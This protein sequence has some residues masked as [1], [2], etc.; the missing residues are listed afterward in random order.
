MFPQLPQQ[1][2]MPQPQDQAAPSPDVEIEDP[3]GMESGPLPPSPEFLDIGVKAAELAREF[4]GTN[5]YKDPTKLKPHL[6]YL[7]NAMASKATAAQDVDEFFSKEN[8]GKSV[9]EI[10][11]AGKALTTQAITD[12]IGQMTAGL[13]D[14]E[15]AAVAE[16]VKEQYDQAPTQVPPGGQAPPDRL[17]EL[18]ALMAPGRDVLDFFP[19]KFYK[20]DIPAP[21]DAGQD[22]FDK[23]FGSIGKGLT[24]MP[25]AGKVE[26]AL[27]GKWDHLLKSLPAEAQGPAKEIATGRG[28]P[29]TLQDYLSK[30]SDKDYKEQLAAVQSLM[31]NRPRPERK[32]KLEKP[33][34]WHMI[35]AGMLA[36]MNPQKAF[37]YLQ[38]P[39]AYQYF[40]QAQRQAK[41]DD[42]FELLTQEWEDSIAVAKLGFE[43]ARED[44][45]NDREAAV[46]DFEANQSA[47]LKADLQADKFNRT[48]ANSL[49]SKLSDPKV[50]LV[51]RQRIWDDIN[52]R[53]P[54]FI[55]TTRPTEKFD[56]ELLS[57]AKEA[58]TRVDT[59]LAQAKTDAIPFDNALKEVKA[60]LG[61]AQ[62]EGE[63]QDTAKAKAQT[64]T[65]LK[66]YE[67]LE[68]DQR[69]QVALA[70][71]L[72]GDRNKRREFQE[73]KF[74]A[75]QEQFLFEV[76]DKGRTAALRQITESNKAAAAIQKEVGVLDKEIAAQDRL[77]KVGTPA[78][79]KA[80]STKKAELV[81]ARKAKTDQIATIKS[82]Q[83]SAQSIID[84][85]N[86]WLP[87]GGEPEGA[88]PLAP[89]PTSA[90]AVVNLPR[91]TRVTSAALG[92]NKLPAQTS[93]LSDYSY[94]NQLLAWGGYQ[95]GKV[96]HSA[97]KPVP[98]FPGH[99]MMPEAADKFGE[100]VA[101]AK[102]DGVAIRITDSY[103]DYEGQVDVKARNGK[104][105]AEPGSSNHG[106][107]RALDLNT[108]GLKVYDWLKANAHKYGFQNPY[109]LHDKK[110]VDENWHWEY[111]G[112]LHALA[113][114]S[115]QAGAA[116]DRVKGVT[117]KLKAE[118]PSY[119]MTPGRTPGEKDR[120]EFAEWAAG[121]AEER[122][123]PPILALIGA[124]VETGMRNL[125]GGDR[126]S[127]GL[128]QQ[129][130]HYGSKAQRLNPD[131]AMEKFLNKLVEAGN[132][133]RYWH[134]T[135]PNDKKKGWVT[136]EAPIG[137]LY[138]E[139]KARA[140]IPE[141]KRLAGI[142]VQAAQASAFSRRYEEAVD[143]VLPLLP[144]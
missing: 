18:Q 102:R 36:I 43:M 74:S 34:G 46:N 104:L 77:M 29:R 51:E 56:T 118:P 137:Q 93:G 143:R 38:V 62:V 121:K 89:A 106:W 142:W 99:R 119:L 134:Q 65:I 132:S 37:D 39:F 16:V 73:R 110:G 48:Q 88:S 141:M 139:A 124:E 9:Q 63:I 42:E 125:P 108:K 135:S 1:P 112:D 94:N 117:D 31:A 82:G 49:I 84:S 107:G 35:A 20:S 10:D 69:I 54:E 100:M 5:A 85:A 130:N 58:K 11:D 101:A 87:P 30:V 40:Q 33:T 105:A 127:V 25:A 92:G 128:F 71:N 53:F 17:Q 129:R 91:G 79:K 72:M 23:A 98:G 6:Q 68:Q 50:P 7:K 90:Q 61:W 27:S 109:A 80:A 140:D 120:Q 15:F 103:R 126:D 22:A 52:N 111:V 78:A 122:N 123:L 12:S 144:G 55:S 45:S 41:N 75:E 60:W 24:N 47:E 96:P 138:A 70:H 44:Y 115:Y 116:A 83:A 67:F 133:K 86:E 21:V 8:I 66:N 95:N 14:D 2:D 81:A 13:D 64:D 28:N 19:S 97:M 59:A 32:A 114:G 76:I 136:L 3:T 26:G 57:E 113:E 131:W 4:G